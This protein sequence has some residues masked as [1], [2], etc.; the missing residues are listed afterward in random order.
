MADETEPRL[1]ILETSGRGGLVALA[2][3]TALRSVRH[4]DEARRHARE[5]APAVLQLLAAAG[6]RPRE[7]H[8]VVVSRGPGSYTG[9][10][11][12]LM[13]AKTLAYASGCAL[14]AVDTF[15][16]IARQAPAEAVV[17]DVIADA[18]Q[19]KVY[20]ERFG[21]TEGGAFVSRIP[22]A[23]RMLGDW[24]ADLDPE[25]WVSGPGL[26]RYRNRLGSEVRVTDPATWNPGAESLL[27][28]GLE[29]H[30]RGERDDPF[31][32][33]PLYL[34]PSAAEQQWDSRPP[35]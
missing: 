33:E 27:R 23:V 14:L 20:V 26:A 21:R 11:V 31:A 18:Q 22:L 30:R 3:G 17:V 5:L 34:R 15:A 25:V 6:W 2:E 24:I 32:V 10:R 19:E 29:R 35:S 9:L 7:L 12:G 13:A 16:A 28:L 8:G 1:L 4:L